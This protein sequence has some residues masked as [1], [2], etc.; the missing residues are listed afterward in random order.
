[1][2]I[3]RSNLQWYALRYDFNSKKIVSFNVMYGIAEI[4]SKKVRKRRGL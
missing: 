4:V 1:M 2:K 3:K